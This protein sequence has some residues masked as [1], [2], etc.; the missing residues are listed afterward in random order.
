M[1]HVHTRRPLA[2]IAALS[3]LFVATV[4]AEDKYVKN[5]DAVFPDVQPDRALV[6]FARPDFM[7]LIHSP[8]FKV[9]VDSTPLG[10]L[11][12]RCYLAEQ[13]EP[14]SHV[15]WGPMNAA[16]RFD[17]Q[18]GRTYFLILVVRY[19]TNNV[20]ADAAWESGDPT[21]VRSMVADRKLVYVK[22][23]DDELAKLREE[24]A[25][26]AMKAERAAPEVHASALPARFENVW[27]RAT[28]K[29]TW[30]GYAATGTLT[31]TSDAIEF[32]SEKE[33]VTIPLKEVQ[34]LSL[35][36]FTGLIGASDESP[37]DML[38]FNQGGTPAFAAFR[39]RREQ[40]VT[41][42]IYLTL[43][44]AVRSSSTAGQQA[45]SPQPVAASVEQTTPGS[46]PASAPPDQ[47]KPNI[48]TGQIEENKLYQSR[49]GM[50][51]VTVPP[52]RNP[53]VRTYQL[54][55]WR[56]KEGVADYEDVA[57]D[58]KDFGQSY[59][60][61]VHRI[62]AS[63]ME[64]MAKEEPK[65]TLSNLADKTVSGWR[66]YAEEPKSQEETPVQTQF[67]EGLF[68]TYTAGHSSLLV[69]VTGDDANGKRAGESGNAR[70]AVLV[71]RKAGSYAYA[72]AEDESPMP[73]AA[74]LDLRKQLESFFANMTLADQSAPQPLAATPPSPAT[75]PS[76]PTPNTQGQPDGFL[77]YE[78]SKEQFTIAIPKD[79]TVYDQGQMLKAS[80]L[81]LP[82]GAAD[83]V[84]F[85]RSSD[86]KPQ[87]MLSP[88]LME[89]VDTGAL[90]SFF[91]QR[92]RADK[93]M[94]CTGFSDKAEKRAIDLIG[95][96]PDFK[97]RNAVEAAHAE[98]AEVGG[99]KGLRINAKGQRG[100]GFPL[101]AEAY[102]A[103]DGE[104]M[105]VFSLRNPAENFDKNVVVFH[106][107]ISTLRLAAAK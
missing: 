12:Q 81:R 86:P 100:Q 32:R 2:L 64:Q 39:D 65:Q 47:A 101:V 107:A 36:R 9:F 28:K 18:A 4:L 96:D 38:N 73:G 83:M 103:S 76:Q 53:F 74:P 91:L 85:Y 97:G 92:Q 71:V 24:G 5:K 80:G 51:S 60:A 25:K 70:I 55:A 52:A 17:F 56:L 15:V 54:T 35:D 62:P 105:Y 6:Y 69:R 58:I 75:S 49:A 20:P 63:V 41:E 13:V 27:Y 104:T 90:P 23:N 95:R 82:T 94:S 78:G 99:C 87:A 89:K 33:N 77:S 46:A 66:K 42:Q 22:A 43:Q 16:Q 26:K 88:E 102:V 31:V 57:F 45:A 106:K 93:G 19:G 79:W 21:Y 61:G 10:W 72:I 98:S 29:I 50:F 59:G 67:G 68:R 48:E 1:R 84:I 3:F 44:S 14:G 7:R 30:K 37:W 34:S 8:T 11:P 40:P